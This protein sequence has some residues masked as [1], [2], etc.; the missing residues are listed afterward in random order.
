MIS[1]FPHNPNDINRL[2]A[3]A[4]IDRD[5]CNLL[6]SKPAAA[7]GQGY[8]GEKFQIAPETQKQIDTIRARSLSEFAQKLTSYPNPYNSNQI[9]QNNK[10]AT[11]G[12]RH[13]YQLSGQIYD[14]YV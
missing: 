11:L 9:D 5:F 2:M 10:L 13:S 12:N 6:L 1:N 8:Y 3:A 7:I 4:V 14:A